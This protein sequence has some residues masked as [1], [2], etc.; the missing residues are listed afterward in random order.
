[1]PGV[2]MR[3]HS[4]VGVNLLALALV[5]AA[6]PALEQDDGEAI[7]GQQCAM[8]HG[9]AGGGDGAM[10]AAMDPKPTNLADSAFQKART[11]EQ[12]ATAIGDGKGLMPG[13]KAQLSADQIQA[14]VSYIRKLGE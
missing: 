3:L 14:L 11:D 8:C 13:Y 6:M 2:F 12:L 5:I 1:M 9:P 10:A 7:Y 4:M